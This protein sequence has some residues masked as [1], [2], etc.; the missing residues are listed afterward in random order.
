M[1]AD[2]FLRAPPFPGV[3]VELLHLAPPLQGRGW[4]GAVRQ[5]RLL[6]GVPARPHPNPSPEGEGL[7]EA[8]HLIRTARI[9][10][11]FW[12]PKVEG[13]GLLCRQSSPA[14]GR[15]QPARADGGGGGRQ[16]LT[17][18]HHAPT[19][20]AGHL[21]LAGEDRVTLLPPDADPWSAIATATAVDC[22]PDDPL[23]LIA[24]LNE[25]P[26]F[27]DGAPVP[28]ATLRAAFA[29]AVAGPFRDPFTGEPAT[30]T[31]TVALLAEW[32]RLL[33][34]NR[35][36]AVATGMAWW[37]RDAIA[38][39]L[40][41]GARAPRFA[42][43]AAAPGLAG[44]GSVAAWVS[45]VPPGFPPPGVPVAWVED[46]FLR[47]AGLGA[48]LRAPQSIAVD[49]GGPAFDPALP[50]DLEAILAHHPFPPDLLDR[51]A[52]LRRSIAAARLGKYGRAAGPVASLP[53]DRRI[54]LAIGQVADDLSVRRGGVG[55]ATM[56][57]FLA[58]VRAAEPHAWILYRPHP[59][60]AAGHR[61]GHLSD[62]QVRLHADACDHGSDLSALLDRADAVHVL[63]SLTGFEALLRGRPVTVHGQPFYA[64][65]GLTR[66]L[67]P[68]LPRRGRRLTID[69]LVAAALILYPRYLD[70][71]TGLPC[72][73]EILVRRLA[74]GRAGSSSWRTALRRAQGR[75]RHRLAVLRGLVVSGERLGG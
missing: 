40:W 56:A 61:A 62:A 31:A 48:D 46:G 10:G 54:V 39:F 30:L 68:P 65:W 49:R 17:T 53:A 74:E 73:P 32:R 28:E 6:Q 43:P 58:R 70:P 29:A 72:P 41:D 38:R 59:D 15:W 25:K 18:A 71:V 24:W 45:R 47:S 50:S 69:Q 57:E 7:E 33:D 55:I 11:A 19:G 64:G 3:A 1:P 34:A 42:R 44:K 35:S 4:G 12:G 5:S 67:A 52:A 37:K 60:V 26:V 8:A 63:S 2:P 14:R 21:P 27:H 23:A 20:D 22:P 13:R 36:I 66:D 75:V 9:G 51:A 16:S